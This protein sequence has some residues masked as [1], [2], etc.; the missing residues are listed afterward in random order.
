MPAASSAPMCTN[1]PVVNAH[2]WAKIRLTRSAVAASSR[3][4]GAVKFAMAPRRSST[5]AASGGVGAGGRPGRAARSAAQ[6]PGR[7]IS[8][9]TVT[10]RAAAYS[11]SARY[12]SAV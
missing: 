9:I 11:W 2:T 3:S 4:R 8:G 12:S 10:N 6:C 7:S 1:G 5:A